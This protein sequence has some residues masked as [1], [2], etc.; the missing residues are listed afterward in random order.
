LPFEM[1]SLMDFFAL[2]MGMAN[3]MPTLPYAQELAR[4]GLD[5]FV[6]RSPGHAAAMNVRDGKLANPAVIEAFPDLPK[7]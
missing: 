1:K 3:P 7:A 5:R 4:L 6:A 2:S